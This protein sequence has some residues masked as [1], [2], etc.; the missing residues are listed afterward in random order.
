MRAIVTAAT[1]LA[2][3][4]GIYLSAPAHAVEL[5]M[6]P[7]TGGK[8][9]IIEGKIESPDNLHLRKF[10]AAHKQIDTLILS[11][12]GGEALE[13]DSMAETIRNAHLKTVIYDF[14]ASSCFTLF[15]AGTDRVALEGAMLGV[16]SAANENG[17]TNSMSEKTTDRVIKDLIKFGVPQPII[18]VLKETKQP[19]IHWL[20]DDEERSMGIK[21]VND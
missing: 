1:G 20:T 21:I 5:S 2:I 10:L 16:H 11:S 4:A 8:I 9:G 18:D 13:G 7:E 15:S 6:L 12:P 14:C 19:D 17:E 3:A